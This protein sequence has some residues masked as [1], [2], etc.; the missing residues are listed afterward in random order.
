MDI[1]EYIQTGMTSEKRFPVEERHSA[2]QAGSG[3]VPVLATP[4]MIAFM[5]DAAYNLL[6]QALPE[7]NTSVGVLVDVRHLAPTPIGG[8][9]R[10][11]VEITEVSD[12]VVRFQVQAWDEREQIGKG[13]HRRAVIDMAHFLK[14]VAEKESN[15]PG[16]P[17]QT[18]TD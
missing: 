14:R 2:L 18:T 8:E 12:S 10:V 13:V 17:D 5:E 15:D 6:Q 4:W 9:A 1:G 16:L 7:G 11:R 3:G